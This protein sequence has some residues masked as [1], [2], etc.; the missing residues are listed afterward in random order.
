MAGLLCSSLSFICGGRGASQRCLW[1]GIRPLIHPVGQRLCLPRKAVG[2]LGRGCVRT[3]KHHMCQMARCV[4]SESVCGCA[5]TFMC[6]YVEAEC[7]C[8][9]SSRV[10]SPSI[11]SRQDLSLIEVGAHRFH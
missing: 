4:C 1:E 10:S 11:I 3:G 7:Q 2:A 5:H 9:A 8:W 6:M